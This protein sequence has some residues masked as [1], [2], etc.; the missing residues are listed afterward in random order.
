MSLPLRASRR[1]AAA[2]NRL[3]PVKKAYLYFASLA[4][5]GLGSA[6]TT[7]P[8]PSLRVMQR[9]VLTTAADDFDGHA[10]S[11]EAAAK[12]NEKR[13]AGSSNDVRAPHVACTGYGRGREAFSR[14]QGLLSPTSMRPLSH[15]SENGS[16]FLAT[17][18]HA[19]VDVIAAA[20][21][22]FGLES[23]AP[24]PSVLK[25]AP[26]LLE[27]QLGSPSGQL[28]A[29]HGSLMR[30]GSVEGL[31]VELSPGTLPAHCSEA[32]S[33]LEDILQG[34]VSKS[35]DLHSSNFW[36]DPSLLEGDHLSTPGGAV[37]GNDWSLAAT[38]VHEL[39]KS[40]NTSPA[41]ICS[42]DSISVHH[43]AD[44]VLTVTGECRKETLLGHVVYTS[45]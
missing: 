9:A 23:L 31:S 25:L 4:M 34:L 7:L 19:E 40:G 24:F 27:H 2:K 41:D 5:T 36:S 33:F 37:R 8:Y 42:W 39:S 26:G 44:D 45:L 38:L 21:G 22:R 1:V 43:A 20:H 10:G 16:C 17:A 35:L 3:K 28:G 14:L 18:S 29:S 32:G 6:S 13:L 11:F 12:W 15:S 30:M